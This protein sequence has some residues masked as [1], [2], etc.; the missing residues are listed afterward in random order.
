MALGNHDVGDVWWLSHR[1]STIGASGA[2]S[3]SGFS[4]PKE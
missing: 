3:Q 1:Q 2:I 4:I